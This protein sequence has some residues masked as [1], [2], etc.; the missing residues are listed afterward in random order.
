VERFGLLA[1]TEKNAKSQTLS[2][3]TKS[4]ELSRLIN[5]DFKTI[6]S[7]LL[8]QFSLPKG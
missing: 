8:F 1:T 5:R 3:P 4:S 7:S 6:H 2:A